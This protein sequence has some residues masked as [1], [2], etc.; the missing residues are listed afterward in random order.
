[1]GDELSKIPFRQRQNLAKLHVAE[2]VF[3]TDIKNI[4]DAL[5]EPFH[6]YYTKVKNWDA[7][8]PDVDP[9]SFRPPKGIISAVS[10]IKSKMMQLKIGGLKEHFGYTSGVKFDMNTVVQSIAS[11]RGLSSRSRPFIRVTSE[12]MHAAA[13]LIDFSSSMKKHFKKIRESVYVFSEV[14][15]GLHLPFGIFGYSEK[16]WIIKN[17]EERWNLATKARLFG[18]EPFGISPAGI[19][20]DVAG[21]AIQKVSQKGKILF[22]ITD[23]MFD[24]RK[25]VK[26]AVEAI[27]KMGIVIIGISTCFDIKD[28]FPISILETEN[29]DKIWIR[30][31]FMRLYSKIFQSEY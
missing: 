17:F 23:G 28:V 4:L 13:F 15:N 25:R 22:V 29:L 30:D 12:I 14:F 9:K 3:N 5:P 27:M 10:K 21:A 16:F 8:H 24:D 20:I 19:A 6:T 2:R 18:L 7:F 1:M 26:F 31:S 11:G